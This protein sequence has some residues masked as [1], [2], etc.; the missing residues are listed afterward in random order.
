MEQV[1]GTWVRRGQGSRTE[2]SGCVGE[3]LEARRLYRT[4]P[5][6]VCGQGRQEEGAA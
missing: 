4:W 5:R 1:M 6:A 2:Q 3:L